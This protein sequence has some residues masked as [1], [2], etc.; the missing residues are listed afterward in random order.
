MTKQNVYPWLVTAACCLFAAAG[1]SVISSSA[2]V[3]M[4]PVAEGLGV[5]VGAVSTYITICTL[6]IALAGPLVA[7]LVGRVPLRLLLAIGG[8]LMGGA[9]TLMSRAG[10]VTTLRLL[11]PVLGIGAALVGPVTINTILSRWFQKGLGIATGIA[12][13]FSGVA[14]AVISV[15][16]E[17]LISSQ[18]WRAGY[19]VTG[20]IELVFVLPAALIVVRESPA[21][22]GLVPHGARDAAEAAEASAEASQADAVNATSGVS[23]VLI[24]L[25]AIGGCIG[26]AYGFNNHLAT[27]ALSCGIA[28]QTA[29]LMMSACMVGD[30]TSKIAFGALADRIGP[31]RSSAVFAVLLLAGI[32]LV[33]AGHAQLAALVGSYL[34]GY[35]YAIGSVGVPLFCRERLSQAAYAPAIARTNLVMSLANAA[36]ISTYGVLYDRMGSYLVGFA[37]PALAGALIA[38]L[39]AH[40]VRR[41][42]S[43]KTPHDAHRGA[44]VGSAIKHHMV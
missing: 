5:G 22:L 2:A 37:V 7:R 39:F 13:S 42:P 31:A 21:S 30:A 28:A 44:D 16:M 33:W 4:Q 43:D 34:L 8:L 6:S 38:I 24:Q 27:Y 14:G 12:F 40:F 9:L 23:D 26:L 10:S 11:A 35:V 1:L 17:R 18:G 29:A 19:A 20:L 15:A 32:A 25:L 3:L 41:V 36:A